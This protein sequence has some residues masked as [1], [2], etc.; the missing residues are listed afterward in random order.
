ML[1]RL[2]CRSRRPRRLLPFSAVTA[3]SANIED[4]CMTPAPARTLQRIK[5]EQNKRLY[6]H[7]GMLSVAHM[8]TSGGNRANRKHLLFAILGKAWKEFSFTEVVSEAVGGLLLA[9]VALVRGWIE[10]GGAYELALECVGCAM[11]I[12]IIGFI[13]RALLVAPCELVKETEE[14]KHGLIN[15]RSVNTS[16]IAILSVI[17]SLLLVCLLASV[18]LNLKYYAGH[19][20]VEAKIKSAPKPVPDQVIPRPAIASINPA[21][22]TAKTQI[23][24]A[25][26]TIQFDTNEP[27][28]ESG[29]SESEFTDLKAKK[30]AA[31]AIQKADEKN[32]R[33]ITFDAMW[34]TM[35]PLYKDCLETFYNLLKKDADRRGEGV[36]KTINYFAC[37]PDRLDVDAAETNVA[38]IMFQKQTNVDFHV[39]I[40]GPAAYNG[41]GLRIECQGGTVEVHHHY[42]AAWNK[43][44]LANM[45]N[46]SL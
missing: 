7:W 30:L 16:I 14:A 40:D 29:D 38:E 24:N 35:L 31:L 26:R 3:K 11:V 41:H 32:K 20:E 21:K 8:A 13:I 18:T 23:T 43:C 46:P 2:G 28:A 27:I 42:V 25:N 6:H 10:S 12:P 22:D 17:C 37:L 45:R 34:K 19:H 1:F 33:Q 4:T 44:T 36:A 39:F 9:F 15:P 5:L